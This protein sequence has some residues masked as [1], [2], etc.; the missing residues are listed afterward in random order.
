MSA[1]IHPAAIVHPHARLGEGVVVGPGALIGEHVVIG[2]RTQVGP[3]AVIDGWTAIGADCRIFTGAILGTECQDLKYRGERSYLRVGD[4]NIIREYVTMNR[5]TGEDKATV[6]GSDNLFMAY[7]HV[8]HNCTIG[9]HNILA[10]AIGM[11][12]H[13]TIMDHANIGG[14]DTIH[15][16]VRIGSYAMIGGG[17][18][19]PKDIPPYILCGGSP[20]RI[21]GINR[22]GLERKGFSPERLAVVERAYRILYRSKLNITQ[23]LERLEAEPPEPEIALLVAFI[24]ASDRGI[25]K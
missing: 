17:S 20:L 15:Q 3:Y 12:G 7:C 14:L 21:A 16:G 19:V 13:V 5:A 4:R 25:A 22:V 10:N 24:K 9:N 2:E 23:A 1:T 6:I 11:A 8:A 18:R